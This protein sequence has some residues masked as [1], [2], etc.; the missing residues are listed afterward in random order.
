MGAAMFPSPG[1]AVLPT[2]HCLLCQAGDAAGSLWGS[3]TLLTPRHRAELTT[4]G[5]V[6]WG[7][8]RSQGQGFLIV[9]LRRGSGG[10]RWSR[11]HRNLQ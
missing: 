1:Q 11:V 7:L 6:F 2:K 4:G 8:A 3:P 10:Q 9:I 5:D